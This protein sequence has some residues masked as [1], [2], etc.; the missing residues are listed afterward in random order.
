MAITPTG[1]DPGVASKELDR[2]EDVYEWIAKTFAHHAVFGEG[3]MSFND[4]LAF[5]AARPALFEGLPP[6]PRA[7]NATTH[8]EK[9]KTF[10]D[11]WKTLRDKERGVG[12]DG[13]NPKGSPRGEEGGESG[14]IIRFSPKAELRL[15]PRVD[16]YVKGSSVEATVVYDGGDRE[17]AG[18][19]IFESRASYDWSLVETSSGKVVDTGP[20]L[21]R[22]RSYRTY[23]SDLEE[24]GTYRL[25]VAVR[26]QY[27]K[28]PTELRL[29]SP[30]LVVV[31]EG[32]REKEVFDTLHVARDDPSKPFARDQSTGR[33]VPKPGF[34][35]LSLDDEVRS[36]DLQIGGLR[37][38]RDQGKLSQQEFAD[39]TRHFEKEKAGLLEARKRLE[40]N[41]NEPGRTNPTYLVR[42]SYV[43]RETSA[44]MEVKAYMTQTTREKSGSHVAVGVHLIDT[45]LDPG[46]PAHHQG[47]DAEVAGPSAD[48]KASWARAERNAI[49]KMAEH[50]HSYNEY[51]DG[52][53]HLAIKCLESDDVVEKSI[54]THHIRKTGKAILGGIAM[55]GG[56]VLIAASPFTGGG[57]AAVGVIFLTTA[58]AGTA[59]TMMSL[60]ERYEKEGNLKIDGRLALDVLQLVSTFMAAG[61]FSNAFKALGMVGK[62]M[63]LGS[64]LGLDV[65]Q[66]VLIAD[67]VKEQLLDV[68]ANYKPKILSTTGE[69]RAKLEQERDSALAQIL[70][71]AMIS[72]SFILVSVGTGVHQIRSVGRLSGKFYTVREEIKSLVDSGD[73]GRIREAVEKKVVSF[74]EKAYLEEALGTTPPKEGAE[75]TGQ[76]ST[77]EA[78][79]VPTDRASGDGSRV[80]DAEPAKSDPVK[81]EAAKTEPAGRLPRSWEKFEPANN[82]AFR[83][84]LKAFRGNDNLAP[85]YSG[86]EGRIFAAD[87]KLTALKRWYKSRLGDMAESLAKLESVKSDVASNPKL[88]ADVAVVVVH[89]RGPDWILRDFD[90]N[91][92]ELRNGPSEAQS[93]RARL[94]AELQTKGSAGE[95]TEALAEL[96]KKLKRDPPS[97]NLHW[98]PSNRKI[99]VIDMQ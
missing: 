84:R 70:G 62:G 77:A 94:I 83:T 60:Q 91:S 10:L 89:E 19:N 30:T 36:L 71:H 97:A 37:A 50:W 26:S 33:L 99:I 45:S 79:E 6:V 31:T 38:L 68:E 8:L 23:N 44:A 21:E 48:E 28:D 76:D 49:E 67:D 11:A 51:P 39:Y 27:F 53:V 78:G 87:G 95:L 29:D 69:Q 90:P 66:G 88:S 4:F 3:G 72:G 5:R 61:S 40:V 41:S 13:D 2:L 14:G 20:T 85:E 24:T 55:V 46:N 22:I 9:W 16:K 47:S 80:S 56:V 17:N 74:E 59:A 75:S 63:Y 58:A 32:R 52:K 86:G 7:G 96:L 81:T 12:L 54:D 92:I 25:R 34:A 1:K 73:Q 65:A 93:A 57:S 15:A 35:P 64:M 98:S 82:D 43:S 18:M 42:G